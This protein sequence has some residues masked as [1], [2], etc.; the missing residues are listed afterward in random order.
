MALI[1]SESE[2]DASGKYSEDGERVGKTII[3]IM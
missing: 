1:I 2:T 3:I